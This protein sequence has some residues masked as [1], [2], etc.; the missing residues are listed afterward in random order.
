M[1]NVVINSRKAGFWIRFAATWI[2]L[3]IICVGVKAAIEI[4]NY[5]G[6][7]VPLELAVLIS[8]LLYSSLL[9]G[10][11]GRTIGKILC[12]LTVSS[13]KGG[14][15]GYL[16]AF[17]RE[18]IFKFVSAICLFLGFVWVAFSRK[19]RGWHDFI[20]GT[21]VTQK[22]QAG[23]NARIAFGI[24]FVLTVLLFAREPLNNIRA[25]YLASRSMGLP[26]EI[27]MPYATRDPSQLVEISSL[28]EDDHAGFIKW[29]EQ[30]SKNP[31]EYAVETA[32]KHQVT[33]FGEVHEV[34]D[35]L[36]FLNEIIPELYYRAGVTCIA[37]GVC[38]AKDN[39]KI[40][41]LVT[42]S[43]FD[44]ELALEIA[45]H[46]PWGIWGS[47]EYW[48]VFETVWKLNQ[49]IPAGKKKMR[50]IGIDMKWDGP[51]M[52]LFT[53]GEG[54]KIK[55][56]I[57]E[58]LRILRLFDDI[59]LML[60]RDELMARNIEKEIIEKGEHGI[61][62]VGLNHSYT[63]YQQSIMVNGKLVR[64]FN[65]MGMML[66]QKYGDEIFQVAF[67]QYFDS[68]MKDFIEKIMG[69]RE[70]VPVAFDVADSPFGKLRDNCSQDY[71]S[72]PG[73]R[74]ADKIC[75]YIYLKPLKKLNKCQ[76][77]EGYVSKEMFVTNKP[78]YKAWANLV[79]M[80]ANN[81]KEANNALKVI[82][83]S[84]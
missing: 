53:G 38:L 17:L 81:V 3:F 26:S 47:K 8:F 21:Q 59:L 15:I 50:L 49:K 2:D 61:V 79:E 67:H 33:I 40:N 6:V 12:G 42:A 78:Y 60:K 5:F 9:I 57:W 64:K 11:R 31:V 76:W 63:N 45:R 36:V 28:T 39:E 51:S 18:T 65:Q 68:V 83:E 55:A 43:E 44:P 75:G 66:H 10:W 71:N 34:K 37:M 74:F 56:P 1:E 54:A 46:Q 29:L 35:Y 69:K 27:I 58:K 19:K 30:N 41:R 72:L 70:H 77:L 25:V 23:K 16:R 73:L 48:D 84:P 82:F 24:V 7:Y 13:L 4:F 80:Q 52:G 14:A 32:A 22:P 20:T 62:W